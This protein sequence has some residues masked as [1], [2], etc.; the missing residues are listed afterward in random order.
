M[1]A[2]PIRFLLASTALLALAL[3]PPRADA[4]SGPRFAVRVSSAVDDGSLAGEVTIVNRGKDVLA[5]DAID[6][7]L[8]ALLPAQAAPDGMERSTRRGAWTVARLSLTPP[9]PIAPR[10]IARIPFRFALC[11]TTPPPEARFLRSAT[12]VRSGERSVDARSRKSGAPAALA[13]A[14]CGDGVVEGAELC[15][16]GPCCSESCE[17]ITQGVACGGSCDTAACATCKDGCS[18]G[19]ACAAACWEGFTQCLAGCTSTYCAPFCQ[20]D[21]GRCVQHC[22]ADGGCA[23]GCEAASGCGAGCRP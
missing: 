11:A 1:H 5:V 19:E 3:A 6:V 8:E 20:V 22:A 15:D 13:C 17:P 18:D 2:R 12:V 7:T 10:T 23:S 16:G 9:A 4:G 21:H 14:T